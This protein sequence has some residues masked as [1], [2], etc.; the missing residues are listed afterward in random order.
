MQLSIRFA[1]P[2]VA[3]TLPAAQVRFRRP[4]R[5][6]RGCECG[7]GMWVN[8]EY[9]ARCVRDGDKVVLLIEDG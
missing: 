6:H 8:A 1:L 2:V 7:K 9:I 4:G 5:I 3:I